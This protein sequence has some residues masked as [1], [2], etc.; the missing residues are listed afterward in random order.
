MISYI[1][2]LDFEATCI[3]NKIIENQEIIEFPCILY[4]VTN[5]NLDDTK[6][7]YIDTFHKFIK[8]VFNPELSD[9][10]KDLTAITQ[11]Q[12]DG[13]DKFKKVLYEN[14]EW[15]DFHQVDLNNLIFVTCGMWDLN[16]IFPK[17]LKMFNATKVSYIYSK[18]INIKDEY[19]KFY[20]E[21]PGNLVK[22]VEKVGVEF[23]G[24]LH[25][26]IADTKAIAK[27]FLKLIENGY[28]GFEIKELRHFNF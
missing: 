9:F 17:N 5:L 2:A 15:L 20:E 11:E 14:I 18:V 4:K 22:M 1:C 16:T 13:G 19:K 24:R 25:S 23:E 28:K 21:K 6:Y 8:P 26:G 3:E 7:E 10:C 12:V 27:I